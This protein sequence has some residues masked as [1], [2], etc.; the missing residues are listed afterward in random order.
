MTGSAMRELGLDEVEA[1]SGGCC[2]CGCQETSE[3][4]IAITYTDCTG[5]T[6]YIVLKKR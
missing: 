6:G 2:C 1:V 5:D 3:N 4:S